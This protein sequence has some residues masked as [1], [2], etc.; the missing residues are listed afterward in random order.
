MT[1]DKLICAVESRKYEGAIFVVCE[2]YIMGLTVLQTV[3]PSLV[4]RGY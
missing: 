1:I 3:H 4:Q 2:E